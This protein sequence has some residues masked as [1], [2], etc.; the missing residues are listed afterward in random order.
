MSLINDALKRARDAQA[1]APPPP[2]ASTPEFRPVEP[3]QMVR[4]G[5]SLTLIVTACIALI[6]GGLLMWQ[7]LSKSP[8]TKP[9]PAK[10]APAE[11]PSLPP[12]T[13]ANASMPPPASVPTKTPQPPPPIQANLV[14]NAAP[15]T[16]EISTSAIAAVQQSAPLSVPVIEPAPKLTPPR[17]QA[18]VYR[19]TRP[20]AMISGKTLFVG[21]KFGDLRVVAISA[22]SATLVGGG[23]TNVLILPQ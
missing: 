7:W 18:I 22:D 19:R 13:T 20:S 21:D 12:T 9:V 11:A 23:Q 3:A 6:L 1:Q 15:P 14:A 10:A 2:P 17:L 8:P 4:P 5:P 16:S